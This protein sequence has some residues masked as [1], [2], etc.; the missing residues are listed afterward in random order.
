MRNL[1]SPHIVLTI[2]SYLFGFHRNLS[3]ATLNILIIR[4]KCSTNI[5]SDA[6]CLFFS[7]CDGDNFPLFGFFVG[8]LID[9]SPS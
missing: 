9:G 8:V 3:E 4:I 7:F 2:C 5:L 1:T 6:S